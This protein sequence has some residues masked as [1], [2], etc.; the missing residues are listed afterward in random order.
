MKGCQERELYLTLS[1]MC[2]GSK[3]STVSTSREKHLKKGQ[4]VGEST[5]PHKHMCFIN[6]LTSK[7]LLSSRQTPLGHN[8]QLCQNFNSLLAAVSWRGGRD[9]DW[10]SD[11]QCRNVFKQK[12]FSQGQGFQYQ[13]YLRGRKSK[14]AV[15]QSDKCISYSWD[16]LCL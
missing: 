8:F 9:V 12:I 14:A 1:Y 4:K 7:S 13:D 6:C 16:C 5:L 11:S 15:L 3:T 2:M 10:A